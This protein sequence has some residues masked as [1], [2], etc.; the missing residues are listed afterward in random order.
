MDRP[1]LYNANE[2][3]CDKAAV[4]SPIF[5]AVLVEGIFPSKLTPEVIEQRIKE[6]VAEIPADDDMYRD[7]VEQTLREAAVEKDQTSRDVNQKNWEVCAKAID[8]GYAKRVS[9]YLAEISCGKDTEF[10]YRIRG[11]Y[12]VW[13]HKFPEE[14]SQLQ[15]IRTMLAKRYADGDACPSWESLAEHEKADIRS[16]NENSHD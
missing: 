11:V 10:R 8:D 4:I 14:P 6:Y 5:D 9:S 1:I 2:V 7:L 3:N 13:F 12:H 16:Y 15:S